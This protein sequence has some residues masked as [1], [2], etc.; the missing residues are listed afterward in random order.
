MPPPSNH[1]LTD[2]PQIVAVVE[3]TGK[4]IRLRNVAWCN[5][6]DIATASHYE[7][8]LSLDGCVLGYRWIFVDGD[9]V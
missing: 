5:T 3:G 2:R 7:L 1:L 8:G 4:V 6:H 9:T